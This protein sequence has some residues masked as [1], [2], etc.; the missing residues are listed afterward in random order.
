[1]SVIL[2]RVDQR[3]LHGQ[4]V[5]GWVPFLKVDG[6]VVADDKIAGDMISTIALT[7]A[8]PAKVKLTVLTVEAAAAAAALGTLPGKRT[9]V[10][11]G[12]VASL[13]R[14][15]AA[16]LRSE[17]V[18]VGNVPI[19]EGRVRVTPSVALS[20][21]ELKCLDAIAAGG[22]EVEARAVPKER[23]CSL[24]AIHAAV[25]PAKGST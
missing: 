1:M 20:P 8:C 5:E 14:I 3:L 12:T 2:V 18:N 7:A 13:D 25:D 23:A 24:A 10:L 19:A 17:Q 22:V 6:V 21:A 15:W 4:V 9:L 11:V 16:G